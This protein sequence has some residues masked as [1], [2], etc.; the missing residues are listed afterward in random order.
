MVRAIWVGTE[1]WGMY[2][3]RSNYLKGAIFQRFEAKY[4]IR[5]L[6]A[7]AIRDYMVPY[8]THDPHAEPGKSYT[9]SSLYLD[10]PDL[11]LCQSSVRGEKNRFKLRI[12]TYG[13]DLDLPVFFEVKR[14]VD[15]VIQKE[16]STVLRE[17]VDALLR[18]YGFGPEVL[19]KAGDMHLAR[20]DRFRDYVDSLSATPRCMVRYEREAYMSALEEPVRIT[21]DRRLSCRPALT[22]SP[23]VWNFA[24]EWRE[25]HGFEVVM[26][27]KFTDALPLWTRRLIQ[28][29]ELVRVSVAKYVECVKALQEAGVR[30]TGSTGEVRYE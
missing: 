19:V 27:V 5:E 10:S 15:Q 21:F 18:G 24:R 11:C 3:E 9:V 17:H 28:H 7:Q 14:R 13:H 30:L 2:P 16:R 23:E 8:V 25:V 26:E 29:F 1:G 12:R 4:F 6:E 20:L 22:Y